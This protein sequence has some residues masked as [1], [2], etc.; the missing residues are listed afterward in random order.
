[1]AVIIYRELSPE[2]PDHVYTWLDVRGQLIEVQDKKGKTHYIIENDLPRSPEVT[3]AIVGNAIQPGCTLG[4]GVYD[5]EGNRLGMFA[6]VARAEEAAEKARV[7]TVDS[8]E[9]LEWDSIEGDGS[10]A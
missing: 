2:M 4:F 8:D 1:M 7:V 10:G 3:E 5:D 6:S 9:G